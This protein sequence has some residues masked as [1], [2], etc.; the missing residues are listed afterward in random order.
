MYSY[1][2]TK[3]LG[4][5][6]PKNK[7]MSSWNPDWGHHINNIDE[8]MYYVPILV[9]PGDYRY[10][11][12]LPFLTNIVLMASLIKLHAS[13]LHALGNHAYSGR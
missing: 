12:S 10:V 13:Q 3:I 8:D 1:E 9:G 2:E 7:T 4:V 5:G 11:Y 6:R